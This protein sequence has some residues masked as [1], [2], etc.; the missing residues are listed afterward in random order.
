MLTKYEKFELEQTAEGYRPL[1]KA[2]VEYI[3][4]DMI[5][6]LKALGVTNKAIA[7]YMPEFFAGIANE[8]VAEQPRR[9]KRSGA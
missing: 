8:L 5:S 1:V 6:N 3:T 9:Y 4:Q 7:A 2:K